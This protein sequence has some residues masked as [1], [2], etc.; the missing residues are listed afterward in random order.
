M[1]LGRGGLPEATQQQLI[2]R[3]DRIPVPVFAVTLLA[4][5]ACGSSA[6]P[7]AAVPAPIAVSAP[8]AHPEPLAAL[9]GG[10]VVLAANKRL[11]F[12]MWRSIV[13]AGQVELAD[14]M[15]TEGYIQHSPVLPTGRAAFKQI[16]SVV[17][18][19]DIPAVVAPPLVQILAEGDLVVMALLETVTPEA[20]APARVTTHFNLFRVEQQR[21]AE[22]WHSVQTAPGPQVPLP[23]HGGPQ[24]VSGTTGV[25]QLA[26]LAADDPALA[27]NKRLVFDM[28]RGASPA[29]TAPI[30]A[31]VAEGEFVVLVTQREH[32]HPG[33]EGLTYTTTW[34]D[35]YRIEGGR[36]V[37]RWDAG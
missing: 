7:P 11:V 33:R 30:V 36:I 12:D 34:F 21:L 18:R 16:F 13:N 9:S 15:L 29:I 31:L 37:E 27:A 4:L 22:H 25:S 5:S 35:M 20:G 2:R 8:V 24:P 3:A 23:E 1:K 14:Q 17:P 26:L 32:P 28:Q 6:N 10:N 19:R